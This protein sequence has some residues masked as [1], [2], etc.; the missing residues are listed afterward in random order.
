MSG[1]GSVFHSMDESRVKKTRAS[2]NSL[3]EAVSTHDDQRTE[4]FNELQSLLVKFTQMTDFRAF[5]NQV[6]ISEMPD[7]IKFFE[8]DAI[9]ES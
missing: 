2:N 7:L 6:L 4:I 1:G 3:D 8:E 5:C 9:Y